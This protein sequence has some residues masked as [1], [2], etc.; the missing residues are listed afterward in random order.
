[1]IKRTLYFGSPA[2]LNIHL[3]QL[4]IKK[5]G[6]PDFKRTVPVEDIGIVLL[7]NPQISITHSVM[8]QLLKNNVAFITCDEKHLPTGLL[9]LLNGHTKQSQHFRHQVSASEP[10]KKQLWQQTVISKIDNQSR[11]LERLGIQNNRFPPLMRKVQSGDST[12]VEGH[13]AKI[14]WESLFEDFNRERFGDYPNNLLNYGYAILRAIVARALTASGLL[15]TLGIHHR[16]QYN[17]YCLAD[18]IM[19]PYRPYVD[20]LVVQIMEEYDE[21]IEDLTPDMKAQLLEIATMDTVINRRSGPLM[22]NVT[23]TTAS[24][25]QC[26]AG[27]RRKILFPEL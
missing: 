17:A 19:E 25:H 8:Q 21:P 7:D 15:P 10:L 27:E 12:N 1:M 23:R 22:T 16:N 13:A 5:P 6:K 3:Q 18:D 24:L 9:L 26:F 2:R 11:L 4:V 14:Y 20:Y